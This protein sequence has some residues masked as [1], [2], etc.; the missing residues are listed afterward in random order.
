MVTCDVPTLVI[1]RG[2]VQRSS[3]DRQKM[4]PWAGSVGK[5]RCLDPES[6]DV[7]RLRALLCLDGGGPGLVVSIVA[8][9][10]SAPDRDASR[11]ALLTIAKD[12]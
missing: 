4:S 10:A 7:S 2:Y 9:L 3:M 12:P 11:G 1:G 6:V 5:D 8:A